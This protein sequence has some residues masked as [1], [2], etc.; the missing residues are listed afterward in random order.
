MWPEGL[1]RLVGQRDLIFFFSNDK[2]HQIRKLRI[3][4]WLA[5]FN[6]LQLV[7]Q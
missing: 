2:I 4:Q 1:Q 7:Q 5:V 6:T 3:Q